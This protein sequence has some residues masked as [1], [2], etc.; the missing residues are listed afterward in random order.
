[1]NKYIVKKNNTK[2]PLV[3]VVM[4][5]YN[6][7]KRV[8]ESIESILN[9]TFKNFELIIIDDWSTDW[10][11]DICK[12]YSETDDRIRL[13]RNEW[14]KWIA[15]TRNRLTELSNADYI[16]LQDSDDISLKDRLQIE[17]DFLSKNNSFWAVSWD[18]EIID[19]IWKKIWFRK[20]SDNISYHILKESP[21]SNSWSMI[22]KKCFEAV[23]WYDKDLN[24]WEDYDLRMRFY[25]KWYQLKNLPHTFL[26][27][28]IRTWQVREQ[29]V[30]SNIKDTLN[31]QKKYISMWLKPTL[32]DRFHIFLEKCLLILPNSLIVWLFKLLKY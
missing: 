9:Q 30:K 21:I 17:Y 8:W 28:R 11:F 18:D 15:Y 4:P 14:N 3:S 22:R 2:Q 19:E 5:V 13:Y 20:Y 12:K 23:W 10:S 32:S 29:N 16:A 27:C 25:M 7:S 26:Q 24:Y 6:T 31:L 1:M